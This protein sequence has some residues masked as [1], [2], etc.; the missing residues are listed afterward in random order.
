LLLLL[1]LPMWR[2]LL[3][4]LLVL[5]AGLKGQTSRTWPHPEQPL[6]L[7]LSPMR[8]QNRSQ[9][10]AA[11]AATAPAALTGAAARVVT[12]AA[13]PLMAAV[14]EGPPLAAVRGAA[15]AQ[16]VT[17]TKMLPVVQL[18]G[19]GMTWFTSSSSS[20]NREAQILGT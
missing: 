13:W 9:T 4:L 17:A 19:M 11:V 2:S 20:S 16:R 7:Q 8:P 10:A 3:P 5:Q 6:L 12:A 18:V 14:M 15:A 1:L